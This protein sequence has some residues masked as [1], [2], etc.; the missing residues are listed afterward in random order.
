MPGSSRHFLVRCLDGKMVRW[1]V[2]CPRVCDLDIV[3]S[4]R[5]A[6]VV[7]VNDH[8]CLV[9]RVVVTSHGA[10]VLD[11]IGLGLLLLMCSL[12]V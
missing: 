6:R 8:W 12:G 7:C 1:C 4:L 3:G 5:Y 11:G 10:N 2:L 9:I